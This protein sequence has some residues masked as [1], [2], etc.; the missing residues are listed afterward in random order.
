MSS[1]SA[2]K[3]ALLFGA[4]VMLA[5]VGAGFFWTLSGGEDTTGELQVASAP[6]AVVTNMPAPAPPPARPPAV[7]PAPAS[8]TP[9]PAGEPTPDPGKRM[10]RDLQRERIWSALK[11]RHVLEMNVEPEQ[12]GEARELAL[13]GLP[14]LDPEYVRAAIREQLVPVAVD[15]Y[16]SALRDDPKLGGELILKFTIV[17]AEEVG[18]VVEDSSIDEE[19]TLDSPF[20]RECMRESVMAVVFEPPPD[21][22]K[23]EVSYPLVF[24]PE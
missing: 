21:G 19:S 7:E 22:G 4:L 24:E 12:E 16:N 2:A 20:I 10:A 13:D 14:D 5:S 9:E 8:A 11:R 3:P 17:G 18:G 15:C 23:V 1:Q 6:P